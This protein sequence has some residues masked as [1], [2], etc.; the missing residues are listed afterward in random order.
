MSNE[1]WRWGA[2]DLAA[3]AAKGEVSSREVVQAHLDRIGEVN[4]RLN[5]V[6]VVLA[7]TALAAADEVDRRQAEGAPLGPLHGVPFT[8]KENIELVGSA[9]TE[10]VAALADAVPGLDAPHVARMKAA[11][12]IPLGRTNLP[13]FGLRW[14]TA[15]GLRGATVNPWDPAKTPGGS[16]GGEAAAL[17]TGM[18]PLG[19]GNDL[20]GSLRVPSQC[21]GTAALKPSF[22]RVPYARSLEP[23][24]PGLAIQLMAVQGPMARHVRDLRLAFAAMAGS[25]PR[26]PVSV[27]APLEGPPAPAP[28]RV[29]VVVDP[30]GGGV[31]PGVAEAVRSAA[32]ALADAGYAVEEAEPPRLADAAASWATLL[33][34]EIV[35]IRPLLDPLVSDEAHRFLDLFLEVAPPTDLAGLVDG[36]TARHGLAR[37]WSEFQAA[38]PLVLGPVMSTPPFEVGYD[39]SGPDAV[40]ELVHR[41]RLVVAVNNLGLPAAAV[42]TGMAS[43]LPQGVQVIGARYREDLCLDAA[44]AI[45]RR[46]G[47]LAPIDPAA[48]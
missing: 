44:E 14:H 35:V 11:G 9:T 41:M 45:E 39:V 3:A 25:D 48:G 29:A 34:T 21:C 31:D 43:G 24:D 22:G 28:V 13:D 15:N 6:T 32:D 47:V 18:T 19:L 7:D 33:S 1:L 17:A 36:Y 4:P 2:A 8:V 26:D 20:G 12:G 30:G 10:G 5:A 40:R 42:P 27:P 37:E 16:S 23:R 38:H 46:L